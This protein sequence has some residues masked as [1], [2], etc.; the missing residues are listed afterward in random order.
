[1]SMRQLLTMED[2]VG[3]KVLI[4]LDREAYELLDLPGVYSEKFAADV[5]GIDEHGMWI[6]HPNYRVLPVYDAKNQYIEPE[7]RV[8]ER[9]RAVVLIRWDF[10]QMV[11]QF[12]ER[13]GW[14]AGA[15]ESDIGFR[16][17]HNGDM[18]NEEV[19]G[20]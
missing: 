1:M 17:P 11:I 13:G 4:Q 15:N 14:R 10:I 6:E 8:E 19:S 12:P 16:P 20:G 2:V 18:N 9:H 7:L 3:T 5:S